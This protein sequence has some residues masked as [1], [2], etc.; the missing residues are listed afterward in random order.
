MRAGIL[1]VTA[2]LSLAACSFDDSRKHCSKDSQCNSD[3]VCYRGFCIANSEDGTLSGASGKRATEAGGGSGGVA[4]SSRPTGRT[5]NASTA[6]GGRPAASGGS[7]AASGG[8]PAP[9]DPNKPCAAGEVRSC[10]LPESGPATCRSG[11]QHCEAGKFG[12]CLPSPSEAAEVCNGLD[13]DC[14]GVVD[15]PAATDKVCYPSGVGGCTLAD[16]QTAGCDGICALGK[17][18]CRDGK[19]EAC[20]GAVTPQQERCTEG[21]AAAADENCDGRSDEICACATDETRTCYTAA[22]A[23]INIGICKAG[24][25][26]CINGRF[27]A[28]LGAVVPQTE[29]C[30]NENADDDCDGMTDDIPNRGMTCSVASSMGLCRTGV[31]QCQGNGAELTCVTPQPAAESCNGLDDDCNGQADEG[32]DLMRDNEHCGSCGTSCNADETCCAGRCTNLNTDN[33]NC[34]A[35]GAEH[36]CA[37]GTTCCSGMCQSTMSDNNHCGSCTTSCKTDETCCA[38]SCVNTK[39]DPNHCGSCDACTMGAQPGCCDGK[40][41]DFLSQQNCGRCGNVCGVL[42]DAGVTCTCGTTAS[43][44]MCIAPVLGVCL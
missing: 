18:V 11:T 3:Q 19:L 42:P 8:S 40:C 26:T 44:T 20:S 30:L 31:L 21:G 35:C 6:N 28:C 2:A 29:T 13:D 22:S 38:G 5:D 12:N 10:T 1:L 23:T 16:G 4:G 41:V 33:S 15:E 36:A 34:G 7:P 25:Q 14:D 24:S 39:T 37:T 17:Q 27:G 43:G 32:F 9:P